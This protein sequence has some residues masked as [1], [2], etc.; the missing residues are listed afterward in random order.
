[1]N[2]SVFQPIILDLQKREKFQLAY[3]LQRALMIAE[4]NESK[5]REQL[6]QDNEKSIDL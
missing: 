6:K 1:M 3:Q 5:K 2:T 4:I